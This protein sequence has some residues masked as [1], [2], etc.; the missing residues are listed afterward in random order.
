MPE[1]TK[2]IPFPSRARPRALP[3]KSRI[4]E[5]A[6]LSE[7]I[8]T[9][10]SGNAIKRLVLAAGATDGAITSVVTWPASH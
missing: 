5:F 7:I 3:S 1:F 10:L 9:K 4:I 8:R 6:E 2:I